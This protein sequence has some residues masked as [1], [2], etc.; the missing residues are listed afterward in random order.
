M[1]WS[2]QKLACESLQLIHV[3]VRAIGRTDP[4]ILGSLHQNR[5]I[6]EQAN[7][8]YVVAMSMG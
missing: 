5:R 4:G 8:A 3:V 2:A 1:L 6:R 7:V